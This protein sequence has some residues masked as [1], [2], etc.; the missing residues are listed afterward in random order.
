MECYY[1]VISSAHLSNGHFRNVKG[2]FRG[3]LSKDGTKTLDYAEKEN[4]I[5]KALED[6]KANF[7]CELCNK[8]YYK[9]QEF[10]NHINSYDHAHKQRLK[11]LKQREFARNVASKS[12]KD[13]RKQEKALQRLHKL[14]ELRKEAACAPGSGPMFRST[15]VTVRDHCN[16][17]LVN[18]SKK[19]QEFDFRLLHNSKA[20][21]DFTSVAAFTPEAAKNRKQDDQMLGLHGQKVGFSFAFPKKASIKLE[22]SAA[23]FYEY[24]DETS[25]EHGL[26]RRS[27]FDPG[28]LAPSTEEIVLGPEETPTSVAPLIEKHHD[29]AELTPAQ[30]S[31]EPPL[32]ENAKQEATEFSSPISHSKEPEH[33]NFESLCVKVDSITLPD[34][35]SRDA[36]RNQAFLEESSSEEPAGNKG[37]GLP[38]NEGCFSQ[39]E[40]QEENDENISSDLTTAEGGIEKSLSDGPIPADSEGETTTSPCKQDSHKRPC[41]PFVPVLN[42]HGSTILQWPSEMLSYTNTEPSISYSCN[43]LCFDF[44]SSRASESLER[45]KPQTNTLNS[46]HKTDS[47]QSLVF[48]STHHNSHL[49]YTD[50]VTDI[51]THPWNHATSVSIDV[52]SAEGWSLEKRRDELVLDASCATEEKEK[53]HNF[54]EELQEGS[55]TDEQQSKNWIKRTHE[56]WF[57]KSRKRKRRRKLCHHHHWDTA[58]VGTGISSVHEKQNWA[59]AN[60]QQNLPNP[61]DQGMGETGLE[62][63]VAELI[64]QSHESPG[65]ENSEDGETISMSTQDHGNQSL[66]PAWN[67]KHNREICIHSKSTCRSSKPISHNRQSN[68]SGLDPGRHNSVYSRAFCSW[69]IKRSS[70]SPCHKHLGHYPEEKCTNQT[71]PIKRAYN[72]LTDELDF[73]HQK[74]RHQTYSCS[75]DESSNAQTCFS[76]ETV[77][78]THNLTAPCKPKRKRRRK[79]TRTYHLVQ[80]SPRKNI[81]V[82]PPKG[83]SVFNN[84]PKTSPQ[85]STEQVK[86]PLMTDY[87]NGTEETIQPTESQPALPLEHF[88]PLKN[89]EGSDCSVS[90]SAPYPD[91]STDSTSPVAEQSVLATTKSSNALEEQEKHGN[92]NVPGSQAPKQVPNI[93]RNLDQSLPKSYLCHYEVAEAVSPEKRNPSAREWL[94]PTPGIFNTPPPLPFKEAHT[95]SHAFLTA[96]QLFTPFALPEHARLLPPENHDKFKDLQCEAYQQLFQQNFFANKMKLSFPPAALQP[97]N[98][99]LQ[100]LQPLCSASVTTIHHTVLQQHAAAAAAAAAASTFKVLQPHQQFLSQVPTLSRTPLPH[101]PVGPRLCPAGPMAIIGPPQLPLIPASI[102]HPN[103]LAFPPLPHTLFPSLLPPHPAV[104]PLQPL[105]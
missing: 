46:P 76:E 38:V 44:R 51:N 57:Y 37:P 21:G 64:E 42:K 103:H 75:S 43:P 100:P 94:R 81:S 29:K 88:L 15:T 30:D 58:K 97:P 72:S 24:N 2:V 84:I 69:S 39:Q 7:Y 41:E 83:I 23:A 17:I 98:A 73:F 93:E 8:Q 6:L 12:R 85:G 54:L 56:K 99:P 40:M 68:K 13:E 47:N 66:Y 34:E 77:R 9:H 82:D 79:R 67:A 48:D 20:P 19:E 50:C 16:E 62:D 5:A 71:Q 36:L 70:S 14:A 53:D 26:S 49:I 10:D 101:L 11:E 78:Q 32:E 27:R 96:E 45:N 65:T 95:N 52:S 59:D 89:I 102:L 35:T 87:A 55:P 63:S 22:S 61:M 74:R 105:F 18:S 86:F 28:P 104:I 4:T 33:N 91:E 90:R 25:V 92:V 80:K 3:P 1:I 60:K 31:K